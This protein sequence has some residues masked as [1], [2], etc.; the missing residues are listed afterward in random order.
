MEYIFGDVKIV[1]QGINPQSVVTN[2]YLSNKNYLKSGTNDISLN[3]LN[4]NNIICAPEANTITLNKNISRISGT[5]NILPDGLEVGFEKILI[6]DNNNAVTSILPYAFGENNNHLINAFAYDNSGNLYIG[7]RFTNYHDKVVNNIFRHNTN[8]TFSR[9]G[10]G[11][12]GDVTDLVWDPSYNRLYVGHNTT[13]LYNSDGSNFLNSGMAIYYPDTDTWSGFGTNTKSGGTGSVSGTQGRFT[14]DY[15]RN[16]LYVSNNGTTTF[17]SLGGVSNIKSIARVDRNDLTQITSLLDTT[18]FPVA[19]SSIL[20]AIN[21]NHMLLDSNKLYVCGNF[22]GSTGLFN[23]LM[24]IDITTVP[25][26]TINPIGL[27]SGITGTA[28]AGIF[29]AVNAT[30]RKMLKVGNEIYFGGSFNRT[31]SSQYV[32]NNVGHLQNSQVLQRFAKFNCTTRV[33]SPINI[34]EW[35][36]DFVYD[37]KY[38]SVR[39]KILFVGAYTWVGKLEARGICLFDVSSGT[40][41]QLTYGFNGA[42]DSQT[43][44]ALFAA[45]ILDSNNYVVAGLMG[46]TSGADDANTILLRNINL[47]NINTISGNFINNGQEISSLQMIHKN[48]VIKLLWNG[49][50]WCVDNYLKM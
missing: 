6:N 23:S 45:S 11:L 9:C 19:N 31:P 27:A 14:I 2:E 34:N 7:G 36:S 17:N 37:L 35:V 25:S 48:Q 20:S 44:G 29:G 42:Y 43:S 33:I 49:S 4:V 21:M 13:T 26:S 5:S 40:Y 15:A 12:A 18:T 3:T 50:K 10:M 28:T 24:E 38:D 32:S 46:E 30:V 22:T 1:S 41:Q 8:G 16:C 47:A 39:N